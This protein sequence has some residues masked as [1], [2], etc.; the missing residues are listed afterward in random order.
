[1]P[2]QG[3][4]GQRPHTPCVLRDDYVAGST[5]EAHRGLVNL[6]KGH[7]GL[8][9]GKGLLYD[10]DSIALA[11]S[12]IDT[13]ETR[14][15]TDLPER[16]FPSGRASGILACRAVT[17]TPELTRFIV[18]TSEADNAKDLLVI[19]TRFTWSEPESDLL[20]GGGNEVNATCV[21]TAADAE[22][23][24]GYYTDLR[25]RMSE[26]PDSPVVSRPD[27]PKLSVGF[28]YNVNNETGED[29]SPI[30]SGLKP[31]DSVG[32]TSDE[33]KQI[34]NGYYWVARK[35]VGQ[36]RSKSLGGSMLTPDWSRYYSNELPNVFE[37]FRMRT[38]T[39][40]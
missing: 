24:E 36:V 19:K 10:S 37:H 21:L 26:N 40:N 20:N 5:V 25:G 15:M 32:M 6:A 23:I 3:L 2:E 33:Y 34:K 31:Q 29:R 27:F 30:R 7:G 11:G 13:A 4:G 18:D 16:F 17:G 39:Q 12:C 8:I 35:I 28:F 22:K 9:T 38:N 1:M 14:T